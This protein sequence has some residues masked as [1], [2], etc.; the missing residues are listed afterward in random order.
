LVGGGDAVLAA[1]VD[2]SF[3][4]VVEY[5]QVGIPSSPILITS[6]IGTAVSPPVRAGGGIGTSGLV[7]A[8]AAWSSSAR[9]VHTITV[10]GCPRCEPIPPEAMPGLEPEF[11]AVVAP[12]GPAA[13]I[14]RLDQR[15]VGQMPTGPH[16]RGDRLH[17]AA[18]F[19]VDPAR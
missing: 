19:R 8:W 18:G 5:R 9:V 17:I 15:A 10:T 12:L 6:R 2:G 1:Q 11:D 13:L 4:V 3:A 7:T 14:T 16:R